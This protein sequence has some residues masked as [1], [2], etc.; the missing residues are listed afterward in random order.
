MKQI[1]DIENSRTHEN[2]EEYD[3]PKEKIETNVIDIDD[4][5]YEEEDILESS[6]KKS[7]RSG[8]SV[9]MTEKSLVQH[10]AVRKNII[11]KILIIL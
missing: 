5:T 11:I 3:D 8:V 9:S 7:R 2:G 4:S 1:Q 10:A 6:V